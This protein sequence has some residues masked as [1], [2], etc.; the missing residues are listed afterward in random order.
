M[1]DPLLQ[2]VT[3]P[4]ENFIY[5][6]FQSGDLVTWQNQSMAAYL[7]GDKRISWQVT[8]TTGS[9]AWAGPNERGEAWASVPY[10][11]LAISPVD[12]TQGDGR[13]I[14]R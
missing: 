8:P 1:E 11:R 5:Q 14:G 6:S 10:C 12:P 13:G 7:A 9:R 2:A 3:T 4:I